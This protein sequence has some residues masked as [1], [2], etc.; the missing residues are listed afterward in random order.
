MFTVKIAPDM[1]DTGWNFDEREKC[2]HFLKIS[3][4][5][6][7]DRYMRGANH[8]ATVLVMKEVYDISY[9]RRFVDNA[10]GV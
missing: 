8:M 6:W 9:Y 1:R 5:E 10:G 3:E 7:I 2:E 4:D